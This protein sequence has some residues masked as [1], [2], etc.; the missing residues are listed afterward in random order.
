MPRTQGAISAHL[1]FLSDKLI[2]GSALQAPPST[3]PAVEAPIEAPPTPVVVAAAPVTSL[4]SMP[5]ATSQPVVTQEP[6]KSA[7]PTPVFAPVPEPPADTQARS[8]NL[9]VH[10]LLSACECERIQALIIITRR[11][12]STARVNAST[13]LIQSTASR[14]YTGIEEVKKFNKTRLT[15]P[16]S[17]T[18]PMI[19]SAPSPA[20]PASP[21]MKTRNVT[22]TRAAVGTPYVGG[23]TRARTHTHTRPSSVGIRVVFCSC[24]FLPSCWSL[25]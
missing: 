21:A 25:A 16:R 22:L 20:V 13:A 19:Q 5:P 4:A 11:R 24:S 15:F 3:Q 2:P 23:H 1:P 18:S 10:A 8:L 9:Q 6:P 14:P 7:T 12:N 17:Q